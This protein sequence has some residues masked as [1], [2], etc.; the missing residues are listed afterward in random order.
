[1]V[2]RRGYQESLRLGQAHPVHAHPELL[3]SVSDALKRRMQ[4][5]SCFNFNRIDVPLFTEFRGLTA[6]AAARFAEEG[7]SGKEGLLF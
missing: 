6:A 3:L 5:R 7:R 2:R 4:G 1:V